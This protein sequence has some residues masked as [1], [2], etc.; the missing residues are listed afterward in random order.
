[1][2]PQEP[3]TAIRALK[4]WQR[5]RYITGV[6]VIFAGIDTAVTGFVALS[7]ERDTSGAMK[8]PV[9]LAL[10]CLVGFVRAQN[11]IVAIRKITNSDVSPVA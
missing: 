4:T 2:T 5:V 1:M 8:L 10:V 9:A 7:N 11:R 6:L 3:T